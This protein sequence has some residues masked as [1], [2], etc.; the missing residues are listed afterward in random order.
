MTKGWEFRGVNAIATPNEGGPQQDGL[1]R[2]FWVRAVT[3]GNTDDFKTKFREGAFAKSLERRMPRFMF[4][5]AGW[6]NPIALLGRTLEHRDSKDG[7]DLLVE[8]DDFDFVPTARQVAHQL[9]SGTLDQ[10]SI[11]FKRT[12]ETR[13]ARDG[14]TWVEEG[15]LGEVSAV[16]EG[17]VRGTKL[18]QFRSALGSAGEGLMLDVNDVVRILTRMSLGDTDLADALQEVKALTALARDEQEEDET[19]PEEPPPPLEETPPPDETE[20]PTE[21][22]E[23]PDEVDPDA[24]L[25]AELDGALASTR[26]A[27]R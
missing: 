1:P 26:G 21:P 18:L 16:V 2:Q 11:G 7:L 12:R 8:L 5:H 22:L 25:L 10:F 6:E 19:P 20:P 9:Q 3:Y 15:R 23:T 17:A 24:D 27:K 13:D 14:G 4:G